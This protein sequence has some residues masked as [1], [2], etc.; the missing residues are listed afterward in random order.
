MRKYRLWGVNKL[1]QEYIL[2][3]DN[4]WYLR[5]LAA[6]YQLV[7]WLIIHEKSMTVCGLY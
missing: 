4:K 6:K 2:W 3:C 1:D 5:K 7:S